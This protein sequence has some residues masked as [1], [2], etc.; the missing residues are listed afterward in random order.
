MVK[1]MKEDEKEEEEDEDD[2][3]IVES[4]PMAKPHDALKRIPFHFVATQRR[5]YYLHSTI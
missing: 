5:R 1:R 3:E 4:F 2:E